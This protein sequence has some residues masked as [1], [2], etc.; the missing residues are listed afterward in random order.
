[1][2]S[3]REV[4]YN[5]CSD[6]LDAVVNDLVEYIKE[7]MKEKVY[8]EVYDRYDPSQYERRFDDGGTS[9]IRNYTHTIRFYGNKAIIN[10]YNYT[11][12]AYGRDYVDKYIIEGDKYDWENSMIYRMQPYP[13]DFIGAVMNDIKNNKDVRKI[14]ES[15]L[16]IK[17]SSYWTSGLYSYI[18]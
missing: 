17:A 14:L 15:K 2:P 1:M 18:L 9:D 10:V 12:T 7:L 3:L 11:K 4:Y 6:I 5:V 13:R 8:E 16:K